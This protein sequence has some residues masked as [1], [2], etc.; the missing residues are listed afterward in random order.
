MSKKIVYLLAILLTTGLFSAKAEEAA[1][2][3]EAKKYSL[4]SP[5]E[6][7]RQQIMAPAEGVKLGYKFGE[8]LSVTTSDE[9]FSLYF[10]STIQ[11]GYG[12]KW[13]EG[14]RSSNKN[15]FALQAVE[16]GLGGNAFNPNFEWGFGLGIYPDVGGGGEI[17]YQFMPELKLAMGVV[18]IPFCGRS[19]LATQ[20]GT[21]NGGVAPSHFCVGSD[22]G[23]KASG[24][25]TKW[26]SYNAYV[27]N[28]EGGATNSNEEV[29]VG[30]SGTVNILGHGYPYTSYNMKRVAIPQLKVGGGAIY[31]FGDENELT[32]N[33]PNDIFR[34]N[35]SIGAT[36]WG[37]FADVNGYHVRNVTLRKTDV[38]FMTS[39][40]TI[41]IP[42]RLDFVAHYSG[43]VP[44]KAG[45]ALPMT[46]SKV[47]TVPFYDV[48]Y[49]LNYYIFGGPEFKLAAGFQTLFNKDGIQN[50]NDSSFSAQ[51]TASF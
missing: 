30:G 50:L 5:S 40:G 10:S 35:A 37:V 19:G 46:K 6:S 34:S 20:I 21:I 13:T 29:V 15:T 49:T 17:S 14:V 26:F 11:T 44:G 51:L 45:T 47:S 16:V 23:I 31:N 24:R 1:K 28:G 27:F 22:A 2:T 43:V 32:T 39:L 3:D 36:F 41:I 8:G 38:G 9:K 7:Q 33:R 25:I 48:A 18:G 12:Y 4:L 42:R